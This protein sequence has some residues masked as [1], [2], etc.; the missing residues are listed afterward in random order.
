MRLDDWPRVGFLLTKTILQ[1]RTPASMR[2]KAF[3]KHS[4]QSTLNVKCRMPGNTIL[5]LSLLI[6][7]TPKISLQAR[8]IVVFIPTQFEKFTVFFSP[9]VSDH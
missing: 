7:R 4:I 8:Y 1:S 3:C 2:V 6:Q 5:P 9:D